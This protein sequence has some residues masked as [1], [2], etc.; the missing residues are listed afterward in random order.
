M[1]HHA[2]RE[3]QG[4]GVLGN[5]ETH[6]RCTSTWEESAGDRPGPR[7]S[8]WSE[9]AEV[10]SFMETVGVNRVVLLGRVTTYGV[11][12]RQHGSDCA[13]FLLAVPEAGKD[14]QTYTIWIPIRSGASM[15]RR[16]WRCPPGNSCWSRA[17]YGNGSDQMTSGN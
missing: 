12:L 4:P 16:P 17:A 14:G 7:W 1:W 5:G 10:M 15:R 9:R 8:L 3:D 11:S 6:H 13:S 2:A